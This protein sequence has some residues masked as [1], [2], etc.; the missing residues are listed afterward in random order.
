VTSMTVCLPVCLSAVSM[1]HAYLR[2]HVKSLPSIM[3]MFSVAES[4]SSSDGVAIRDNVTLRS[5]FVD[6][7]MFSHNG[8]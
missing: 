7:V 8:P 1:L 5:G 6:D 2:K 4:Q 3:R